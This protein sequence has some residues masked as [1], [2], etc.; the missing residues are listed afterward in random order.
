MLKQTMMVLAVVGLVVAGTAR[1]ANAGGV[2]LNTLVSQDT[3]TIGIFPNSNFGSNGEFFI[4]DPSGLRAYVGV[5]T[6]GL[7]AEL[8]NAA[9]FAASLNGVHY[10]PA[11]TA[12]VTR[13]DAAWSEDTMTWNNQPTTTANAYPDGTITASVGF[14]AG[15]ISVDITKM[16][17][18]WGTGAQTN[19]GLSLSQTDL[20]GSTQ[21]IKSTEDPLTFFKPMVHMSGTVAGLVDTV[22]NDVKA[23]THTDSTNPT[24]NY[25]AND[26][27]TIGT[28]IGTTRPAFLEISL[29]DVTVEMAGRADFSA[30][31]GGAQFGP[32]ATVGQAR[33]TETWDVNT[34][35]HENAPAVALGYVAGSSTASS[36]FTGGSFS[37]DITDMVKEWIAGTYD[38]YGIF[39][40]TTG[41]ELGVLSSNHPSGVGPVVIFTSTG[42]VIPE[43]STFAIWALG[44]LGL[45]WYARRRRRA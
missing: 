34:V 3:H 40:Y 13:V 42:P 19:Y 41:G 16:A 29:E 27:F 21:N 2:W 39:L 20:P 30:I 11:G 10:G 15:N 12:Q 37:I 6:L 33:I 14:G 26:L 23:D 36:G 43:P 35:T 32:A 8:A 5:D 4:A 24:V 44:L 17:K 38:N 45:A 1:T 18:E 28:P 7:T 25:A 22:I 31:L 9:D